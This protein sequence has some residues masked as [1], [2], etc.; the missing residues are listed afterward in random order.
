MGHRPK[1]STITATEPS[2]TWHILVEHLLCAR[3][4]AGQWW[5]REMRQAVLVPAPGRA[6]I[7]WERQTQIFAG[8]SDEHCGNAE[9]KVLEAGTATQTWSP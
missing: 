6:S 9:G 7:W 1:F 3:P 8:Q 2:Y 5:G 4:R